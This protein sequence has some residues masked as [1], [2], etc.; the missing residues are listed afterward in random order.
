MSLTKTKVSLVL[1]QTPGL[2]TDKV[3]LLGALFMHPHPTSASSSMLVL[4]AS[5]DAALERLVRLFPMRT[6]IAVPDWL[7]TTPAA[8]AFSA[9][10]VRA[11]G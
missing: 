3:T 1:P 7:I 11:A 4:A 5:N 9:A 8:D 10:G 2:P 6:G